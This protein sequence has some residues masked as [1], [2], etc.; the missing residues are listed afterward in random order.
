MEQSSSPNRREMIA[1]AAAG[2][3]L[4]VAAC[5]CGAS[6]DNAGAATN[7]ISHGPVD[8]GPM[9]DYPTDGVYDRFAESHGF[10]VVREGSRVFALSATCTHRK[11]PLKKYETGIKCRCHGSTFTADGKVT[12]GPASRDLPRFAV[13]R[14]SNGQ[15]VVHVD[16]PADSNASI[17]IQ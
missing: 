7:A 2:A 3:T 16:R 6:A 15:L 14:A 4:V 12:R 17:T 13:D 11:C 5:G 10:F 1:A 9:S 8:V